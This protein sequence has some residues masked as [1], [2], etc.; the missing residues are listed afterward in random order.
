MFCF[1]ADLL[2]EHI[3]SFNYSWFS[4]MSG[5][6]WLLSCKYSIA[7]VLYSIIRCQGSIC[8]RIVRTT[9]CIN[10]DYTLV[11]FIQQRFCAIQHV[12][13]ETF[14]NPWWISILIPL[15]FALG[16]IW[17]LPCV[18]LSDIAWNLFG[19]SI[20]HILSI[21]QTSDISACEELICWAQAHSW[22]CFARPAHFKF[23]IPMLFW[24]YQLL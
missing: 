4:L 6:T 16:C 10:H 19:G 13:A 18:C 22:S 23:P 9:A 2:I 21:F 20:F 5:G 11:A 17:L 7:V 8:K 15:S 1:I 12:C 3:I 14:H 24:L